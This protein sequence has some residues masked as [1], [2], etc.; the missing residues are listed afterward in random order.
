MLAVAE[1]GRRPVGA[2]GQADPRQQARAP[3]RAIR[4]SRRASRQKWNECPACACTASATLSSTL[5]SRN[6][7]VIWNERASPSALRRYIGS[8]VMSW[9]A[10]TMLAGVGRELA[11]ELGDQR[12]L[13]GAVRSDHRVQLAGLDVEHEIVGGDDALETLGQVARPAAAARS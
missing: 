6:S 8:A 1:R 5:R 4:G 10:K 12:G 2:I 7:D 3:A 9:P 13:A 11:A